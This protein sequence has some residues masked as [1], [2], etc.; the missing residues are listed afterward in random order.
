M[1]GTG[2]SHRS[3]DAWLVGLFRLEWDVHPCAKTHSAAGGAS[4]WTPH[5]RTAVPPDTAWHRCWH[6]H[7][8][9]TTPFPRRPVQGEKARAMPRA[10]SCGI[11]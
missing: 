8:K 6:S 7:G 4:L 2:A 1:D 9:Q 3:G 11:L 5:S 10:A